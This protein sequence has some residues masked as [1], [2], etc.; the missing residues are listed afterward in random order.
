MVISFMNSTIEHYSSAA[1]GFDG[2]P[3]LRTISDI[4]YNNS[5]KKNRNKHITPKIYFFFNST[6]EHY[7]SAAEG[8]DGM[9]LLRAIGDFL[10]IFLGAFA[11]GSGMGMLNALVSFE[12]HVDI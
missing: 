7:S 5:L 1:V 3:L 6:I 9:A 12:I 10:T 2:M 4:T 11:L 8:F